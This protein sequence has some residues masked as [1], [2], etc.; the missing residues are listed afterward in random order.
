MLKA[1]CKEMVFN[2]NVCIALKNDF[3]GYNIKNVSLFNIKKIETVF[4]D[5][6]VVINKNKEVIITLKCP[7]CHNYHTYR[8]NIN[9]LFKREMSIGGC[10]VLGMPV[11]FIGD[12]NKITQQVNKFIEI[13]NKMYA[14]Y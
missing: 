7:I 4:T 8:Y 5:F 11:F 3:G 1:R 12:Y 2:L 6:K 10:E 13:N 9:E 14:M